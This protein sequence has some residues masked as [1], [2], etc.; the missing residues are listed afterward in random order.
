MKNMIFLYFVSGDL[1]FISFL[2]GHVRRKKKSSP[3]D[4][5]KAKKRKKK[6]KTYG[7]NMKLGDRQL[8]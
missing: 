4:N 6:K 7:I 8:K 5:A 3:K 1:F 2:V